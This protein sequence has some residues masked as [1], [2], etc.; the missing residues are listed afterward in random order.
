M[1]VRVSNGAQPTR[2]VAPNPAT[3]QNKTMNFCRAAGFLS[4]RS[5]AEAFGAIFAAY[6]LERLV[7]PLRWDHAVVSAAATTKERL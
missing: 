1:N 4:E 2:V 5:A 7:S 6:N 3:I